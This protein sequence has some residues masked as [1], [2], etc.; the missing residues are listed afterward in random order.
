MGGK[1]LSQSSKV[2]FVDAYIRWSL[3]EKIK[4]RFG[5]VSEGFREI[6]GSSVMVQKMLD[7]S[8]LERILCGGSAPVDV[9]AIQRRAVHQHWGE[10]DTEYTNSFWN[11]LAELPETAQL[12]FVVFVTGSDRV[13]LTGWEELRVKIQKNGYSDDRLPTAYT[14]FSLVLLPKYSSVTI[15]RERLLSAISGAQGFGLL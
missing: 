3:G 12:Q 6:M 7:A 9:A 8:Q 4:D 13:P 2:E 14:C 11:L 1:T 5:P 10:E 15:L